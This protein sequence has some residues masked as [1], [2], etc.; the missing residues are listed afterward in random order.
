M[1]AVRIDTLPSTKPLLSTKVPDTTDISKEKDDDILFI[2]DIDEDDEIRLRLSDDEELEQDSTSR[3]SE[4]QQIK[5][6]TEING[7]ELKLIVDSNK[8]IVRAC[9]F[10][11][12]ASITSTVLIVSITKIIHL[13]FSFQV[14][15]ATVTI[16]TIF[17]EIFKNALT[18]GSYPGRNNRQFLAIVIS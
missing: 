12:L 4:S 13:L 18:D 15:I 16:I 11:H 8:L 3:H 7:K 6:D 14:H 17:L 2:D 10:V 5:L 1:D 9:L